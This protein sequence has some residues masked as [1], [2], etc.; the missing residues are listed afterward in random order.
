MKN[1][2]AKNVLPNIMNN[3]FEIKTPQ[4]EKGMLFQTSHQ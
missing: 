4:F 2:L 3:L 1:I